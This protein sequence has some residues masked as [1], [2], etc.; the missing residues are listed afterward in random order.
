MSHSSARHVQS[1]RYSKCCHSWIFNFLVYGFRHDELQRIDEQ[2]RSYRHFLFFPL[3]IYTRP[4]MQALRS[5]LLC[6]NKGHYYYCRT[7]V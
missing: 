2:L 5:V 6:I 7:Y 4:L 3:L 1:T